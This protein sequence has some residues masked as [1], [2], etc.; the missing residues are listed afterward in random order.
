MKKYDVNNKKRKQAMKQLVKINIKSAKGF[1]KFCYGLTIA[2]RVLAC[3]LGLAN[4]L[5]VIFLSDYAVDIIFLIM[6]FGFPYLFSF[7]PATVYIVSC[8]GEYRFRRRESLTTTDTGFMYSYHDDRS[9][10]T[11]ERFSYNIVYENITRIEY[12]EKTKVIT[13]FG[14]IVEETY[15]GGSLSDKSDWAQV[16]FLN[17]FDIDVAEMVKREIGGN[18]DDKC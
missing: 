2:L 5:Y 3:V 4:I 14:D 15:H 9:N 11:T 8:G 6:T 18:Q 17:I 7:L 13:L 12:S 10:I 1:I 16:T